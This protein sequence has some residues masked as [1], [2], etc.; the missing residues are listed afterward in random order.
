M[1]DTQIKQALSAADTLSHYKATYAI[2]SNGNSDY[3]MAHYACN[4]SN[5]NKPKG[6]LIIMARVLPLRT[7][8]VF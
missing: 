5:K 1:L 3:N 2:C 6:T 7:M 4:K 8:Y